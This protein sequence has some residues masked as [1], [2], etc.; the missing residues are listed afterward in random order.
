MSPI[1]TTRWALTTGT[2]DSTGD[3]TVSSSAVT[4][5]NPSQPSRQPPPMTMVSTVD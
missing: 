4:K 3:A 2:S 1:T 5:R